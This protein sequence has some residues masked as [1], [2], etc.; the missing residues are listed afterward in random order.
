MFLLLFTNVELSFSRCCSWLKGEP[1]GTRTL[2]GS[3]KKKW[4]MPVRPVALEPHAIC[5]MVFYHVF[6]EAEFFHHRTHFLCL[7]TRH[8]NPRGQ[9][10]EP[11]FA[12]N[13]FLLKCEN[14]KTKKYS[15]KK[16]K[17]RE[18]TNIHNG[19]SFAFCAENE[20]VSCAFGWPFI[21]TL[22]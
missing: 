9:D 18:M 3:Q 13:A 2:A 7:T 8:Q 10:L 15:P 5:F 4:R 12:D 16:H 17:W 14:L 1:P 19:E 20:V 11:A 22:N 21:F 6:S